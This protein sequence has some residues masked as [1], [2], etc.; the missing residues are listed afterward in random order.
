VGTWSWQKNSDELAV[1]LTVQFNA[2]HSMVVDGTM[3]RSSK[4]KNSLH[5]IGSWSFKGDGILVIFSNVK[6]DLLD[7]D[8][9]YA[10]DITNPDLWDI[11]SVNKSRL[12][13]YIFSVHTKATFVRLA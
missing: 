2:N 12:V 10:F 1:S 8:Y 3:T 9:H 11:D 4:P 5:A 13:M 7:P 6:Y